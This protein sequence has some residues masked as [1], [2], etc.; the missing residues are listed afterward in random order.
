MP[1]P[2]WPSTLP[3]PQAVSST[4]Y[5]AP[6]NVIETQVESGAPK[7]RRR[8]T[9]VEIPFTC[10]LK[11]T[12]TQHATLET[13]YYT[14]LQQVLPFDWTDFR[15]GATATYHFTKDGYQSS[16]IEGSIDRWLVTLSLAR[17]P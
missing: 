8:F 10:T 9:S 11:L 6:N 4:A 16:Y 2:L 5:G 13:F 1:N 3:A 14:T 15:T 7:R 12:Q 17:Q